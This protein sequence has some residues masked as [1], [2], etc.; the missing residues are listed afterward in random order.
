MD[1]IVLSIT[2]IDGD[3]WRSEEGILLGYRP[4]VG[5]IVRLDVVPR[6]GTGGRTVRL[7][8]TYIELLMCSDETGGNDGHSMID[9]IGEVLQN[10]FRIPLDGDPA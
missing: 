2:W 3:S 5:D 1:H 10:D 9:C 4:S 7:K 8:I 6:S